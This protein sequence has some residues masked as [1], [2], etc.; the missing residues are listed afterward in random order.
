MAQTLTP[1]AQLD[2]TLTYSSSSL[3]AT[4]L[5]HGSGQQ[6][7]SAA[8]L[9]YSATGDI[10]TINSGV[11]TDTPLTLKGFTS[12]T[13]NILEVQDVSGTVM[14]A[15]NSAGIVSGTGLLGTKT[16]GPITCAISGLGDANQYANFN[17]QAED[18]GVDDRWFFSFRSQ[19]GSIFEKA[20]FLVKRTGTSTFD[21]PMIVT[22]DKRTSFLGGGVLGAAAAA[23]LN[24]FADAA[25]TVALIAQAAASQTA[26]IFQVRNSS[27]AVL[28]SFDKLG[29]WKPASMTNANAPNG[30]VY[31][32]TTASK[33]VYKDSG[34]TVNNLY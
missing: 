19:I 22:A 11:A 25:G 27:A 24:A 4:R 20:F 12:Q 28:T 30:S 10:L 26:D 3:T 2:A 33:L 6:V 14:A 17:F 15:V 34:G 16:S 8:G 13:A 21:T 1:R 29:A 9:V 18:V 23:V 5:L 31:Y 7:I 32:S